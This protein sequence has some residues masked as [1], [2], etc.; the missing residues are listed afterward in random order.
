MATNLNGKGSEKRENHAYFTPS[1]E[2]A[3]RRHSAGVKRGF[4]P[5]RSESQNARIRRGICRAE[6]MDKLRAG[7]LRQ[8]MDVN[9]VVSVD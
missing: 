3:F 4:N 9:A 7:A 2:K 1:S 6:P 8:T 5:A